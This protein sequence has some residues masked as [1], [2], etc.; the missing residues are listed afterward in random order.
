MLA[1]RPGGYLLGVRWSPDGR[2]IAVT[3]TG[4]HA[5]VRGKLIFVDPESGAVDDGGS[6][7][8]IAALSR[9][10]WLSDSSAIL[11]ALMG[12]SVGNAS[13]VPSPV[14]RYDLRRGGTAPLFWASE[15]FPS[16]GA[17]QASAVLSVVGP[18]RVCFDTHSQVETLREVTSRGAERIL[19]HGTAS[20]RTTSRR[21]G[22]RPSPP[23]A[24]ACSSA[25]TAAGTWRSG[26]P[27]RTAA[28][29]SRWR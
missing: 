18:G 10:A 22:I 4:I 11:V 25:P 9:P 23:T 1:A 17:A 8:A 3:E 7:G 21:T 19:T 26:P 20:D 2:R 15:L 5:A 29:R 12:N 27:A 13:G 16:F 6:L 14:V 24:A 28:A